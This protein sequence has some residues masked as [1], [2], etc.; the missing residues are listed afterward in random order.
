MIQESEANQL[1]NKYIEL[2]SLVN[3]YPEDKKIKKDYNSHLA[4]CL[5]KFKYL[6]SMR[7][8]KYVGFQ[9]FE[10]LNQEG[11]EALLKAMKS[12]DPK[13]GSFFWWGHKYI[14]TRIWRAAN[15]HT[16]IKYPL[17]YA[18]SNNPYKISFI[19]QMI[20][21]SKNQESF[22]EDE[23]FLIKIFEQI[24]KLKL[25]ESQIIKMAFGIDRP[26]PLPINAIAKKMLISSEDCKT[27]IDESIKKIKKSLNI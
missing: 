26:K 17:G 12:Y 13:K 20:D 16:T 9:N 27:I 6:I 10:D 22:I 15:S 3:D 7:T 23:E 21:P 4:I 2:R 5:D 18:K 19:P 25:K 11:Y 8:T 24:N 1:I 14:E